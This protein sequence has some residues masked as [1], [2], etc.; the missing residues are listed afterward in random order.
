MLYSFDDDIHPSCARHAKKYDTTGATKVWQ[1][2]VYDLYHAIIDDLGH[3]VNF[4]GGAKLTA[5]AAKKFKA[6]GFEHNPI[7]CNKKNYYDF[8]RTV[9]VNLIIG[10]HRG[11]WIIFSRSTAYYNKNNP[12]FTNYTICV[13]TLDALE[14]HGYIKQ[15]LG[16]FDSKRKIGRRT[17]IAPTE[18]FIA[19]YEDKM[20]G[21]D[22]LVKEGILPDDSK[23]EIEKVKVYRDE[24]TKYDLI[25]L[26]TDKD[27]SGKRK[28]K[29]YR[30]LA[31]VRKMKERLATY[32]KV[33]EKAKTTAIINKWSAKKQIEKDILYEAAYDLADRVIIEGVTTVDGVYIKRDPDKV[34]V[35][36][37]QYSFTTNKYEKEFLKATMVY[38]TSTLEELLNN[39]RVYSIE[40]SFKDVLYKRRFQEDWDHHGRFYQG[41]GL[42][43]V[44]KHIRSTIKIDGEDTVELDY[45]SIHPNILYDLEKEKAPKNIYCFD[46]NKEPIKRKASKLLLLIDINR[47][48]KNNIYFSSKKAFDGLSLNKATVTEIHRSVLEHNKPIAKYLNTG[49]GLTLMNYDSKIADKILYHFAKKDIPVHCIHDS[50]II[51]ARHK[52]ELKA[53]MK[54][55]YMKV[56]GTDHAPEISETNKR[57]KKIANET[58]KHNSTQPKKMAKG[59]P[60]YRSTINRQPVAAPSIR[61][62]AVERERKIRTYLSASS[63]LLNKSPSSTRQ[64][65]EVSRSYVHTKRGFRIKRTIEEVRGPDAWGEILS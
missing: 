62:V 60:G 63:G 22:K 39:D 23:A 27:A 14:K 29:N 41:A 58:I 24:K 7:R 38:Q 5:S 53:V 13:K 16:Y 2:K 28:F 36:K 50:F 20:F 37:K 42:Q 40:V 61:N 10:L 17:V 3:V 43:N 44:H 32:N 31:P 56:M 12:L 8:M 52:D 19:L 9:T 65:C 59:T 11:Q 21:K 25:E 34:E 46:K 15:K 1:D 18:K 30:N 45:G 33:V 55:A 47:E 35:I 57:L 64:G 26:V 4:R 48:S 49:I 54:Q 6:R 51:A